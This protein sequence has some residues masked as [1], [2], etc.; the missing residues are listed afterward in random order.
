MTSTKPAS[1]PADQEQKLESIA[2]LRDKIKKIGGT[3][4]SKEKD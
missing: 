1:E 2:G 4:W 3:M